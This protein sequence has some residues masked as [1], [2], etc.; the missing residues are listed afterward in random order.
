V[1]NAQNRW[2]NSKLSTPPLFVNNPLIKSFINNRL[3]TYIRG[4]FFFSEAKEMDCEKKYQKKIVICVIVLFLTSLIP[5]VLG[6]SFDDYFNEEENWAILV[7][8][9]AH[10]HELRF[11]NTTKHAYETFKDLGYDD[12]HIYYMHDV[13]SS[14]PGVDAL[15]SKTR[16]H[17]SITGWMRQ[18]SD[19]NDNCCFYFIGHGGPA[20]SERT[21]QIGIWNITFQGWDF[22][23]PEELNDWIDTVMCNVFTVILDSCLSGGF[24][25]PL[26]RENR[27]VITSSPKLWDSFALSQECA[28]SYHFINKLAEDGSYGEAWMYADREQLNLTNPEIPDYPFF[29]RLGIILALKTT[30][31]Q[32]DDNG[33]GIGQGRFC[34]ADELPTGGDG[35]L[36][37]NTYPV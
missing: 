7:F 8:G 2:I 26:S 17:Q 33:D 10:G 28:F 24:I 21:F 35:Y 32:L 6:Y 13:D 18:N 4:V 20:F 36:A 16:V 29:E 30:N 34:K 1:K 5:G 9:G 12:D 3:I 27:I 11:R 15:S 23:F 31:P 14:E 22:I 25:K 19:E 37:L